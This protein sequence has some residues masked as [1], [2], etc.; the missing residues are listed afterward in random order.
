MRRRPPAKLYRAMAPRT[1]LHDIS[2]WANSLFAPPLLELRTCYQNGRVPGAHWANAQIA[3]AQQVQ[4]ALFLRLVAQSVREA[5]RPFWRLS[6]GAGRA[7]WG[8]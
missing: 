4:Y 5:V 6:S 3:L 1:D 7:A 2:I 8:D